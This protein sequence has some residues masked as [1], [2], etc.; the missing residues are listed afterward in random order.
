MSS[1]TPPEATWSVAE[2]HEAVGGL[3]THVFGDELW[4]A[5][6][7][8]NLKRSP[9]RHVFFDLVEPDR[10][11]DP[12]RPM[13]SVTLFDQ[14]RQLVNQHLREHGP[15]VRMDDGV[16]VRVRGRLGVFAARSSLQ[17]VMSGIDPAYTLGVMELQRDR[18]LAALAAD[19]LLERNAGRTLPAV[20][21]HVAL[22]T[23][24][25]SAAHADA[26][27]ELSRAR[28]GLRVS[29]VDARTQG[30]DAERS[31]VAAIGIAAERG[32]DVV[33]VVRGGGARTDLVAFD[34]EAVARA[35][36]TCPLPVW[37]GVGHETD[38]T[39]ADE[40]AHTAHKTPTAAAAAVVELLR[41]V[42][43][44]LAA[45]SAQLPAAAR[46][47]LQRAE[48]HLDLAA[49]RAG[50]AAGHQLV[51]AGRELDHL[52]RSCSLAALRR[53]DRAEHTA[54][55]AVA[56]VPDSV[57]R[58][59]RDH[60]E[61]LVGLAARARAHDPALALARGWTIT[62]DAAGTVVRSADALRPG[63][64]LHTTLADGTVRS[65]VLGAAAAPEADA[66]TPAQETP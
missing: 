23:S 22:V 10:D 12:T 34:S 15:T 61:R 5:G 33:L 62:R 13:L 48:Q 27:D 55:Q 56:R 39:V 46:G 14:D 53:L 1:A 58:G 24:I 31:L 3:L 32:A 57:R 47:R 44:D 35:I 43:S 9:K 18:V 66:S 20:P 36:A 59:L 21:L 50:R 8:R 11:G 28:L 60:D 25:G 6:E 4:V 40:V 51:A 63:D 26:L 19:G 41:R 30:L 16:K 54:Q 52:S 45:V 7:I 17:L 49:R 29:V 42:H 37:T 2:L 65:T 38:R 64:E